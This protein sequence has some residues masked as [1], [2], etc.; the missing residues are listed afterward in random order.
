MKKVKSDCLAG[1]EFC[2]LVD[3][4]SR[5]MLEKAIKQNGGR[6]VLTPIFGSTYMVRFHL[7]NLFKLLTGGVIGLSF[8]GNLFLLIE[9]E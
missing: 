8:C 3:R 9:N 7:N 1:K 2:V 5:E 6:C 4:E